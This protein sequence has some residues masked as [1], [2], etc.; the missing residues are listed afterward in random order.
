MTDSAQVVWDCKAIKGM[1]K[2]VLMGWA[3][4]AEDGMDAAYCSKTTVADFLG[5]SLDTIKRRTHAL[6]TAGW[7]VDTGERKQWEPDCWTPV[8]RINLEKLIELNFGS[9]ICTGSAEKAGVQIAPQ[10][11]GSISGSL[12]LPSAPPVSGASDSAADLRSAAATSKSDDQE[13]NL[14]TEN[15]QTEDRKPKVKTC[16]KCGVPWSRDKGHLCMDKPFGQE[17]ED[18]FDDRYRPKPIDP[19]WGGEQM[20]FEDD[21]YDG[22][23]IWTDAWKQERLDQIAS[24]KTVKSAVEER[25]PTATPTAFAHAPGS[26]SPP[27]SLCTVCGDLL[28]EDFDRPPYCSRVDCQSVASGISIGTKAGISSGGTT[29]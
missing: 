6:V 3:E 23:P 14:K 24:Q 26:A 2:L 19:N 15:L 5:V 10:G 20:T 8:Y 13:P 9:A 1:D 21:G 7:L 17:P 16:P 4:Q 28:D 27:S 18:G 29:P 25:K 11:S 12:S 22:R